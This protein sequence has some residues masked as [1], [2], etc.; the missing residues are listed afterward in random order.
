MCSET[1]TFPSLQP[2]RPI[3]SLILPT[4]RR[5]SPQPIDE[6]FCT[7]PLPKSA[8]TSFRPCTSCGAEPLLTQELQAALPTTSCVRS[9]A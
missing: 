9:G 6:V 4:S 7:F 8:L 3:E 5:H 1:N 2:L